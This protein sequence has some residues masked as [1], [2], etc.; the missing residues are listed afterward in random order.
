[1]VSPP[2]ADLAEYLCDLLPKPLNRAFFLNTGSETNEAA[3]KIAKCATGKFEIVAFSASYHGLTGGAGAATYA[4]GRKGGGPVVPGS[5]TFPTPNAM[6]SPFRKPDGSYD[7]QA[8]L[9]YGWDL[10]DR[11]T[12]GSLCAFILEPILS[13]AGVIPLPKGYMAA[14]LAE[15]RKRDML[16]I[17]DEA[18]TGCGRT[19]DLWAFQYDDIVPDILTLSKTLGAGL[20]MAAV[21]TNRELEDKAIANGVSGIFSYL[22]S[23]HRWYC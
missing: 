8:E 6:T 4:T 1:M 23:A 16:L 20:P 2:V 13:T 14:T 12:V 11:S 15:C 5:L 19:G 22:P 7:W 18:Q 9:K 17:V 10:I 21:V 3:L